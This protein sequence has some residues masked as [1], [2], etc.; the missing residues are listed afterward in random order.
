ME[1]EEVEKNVKKNLFT[2]M[3]LQNARNVAKTIERGFWLNSL[4]RFTKI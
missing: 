2:G 4:L 3:S 1:C